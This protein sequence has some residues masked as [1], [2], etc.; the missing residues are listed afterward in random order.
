MEL[1]DKRIGVF[2]R[3]YRIDET[4]HEAIQSVLNQTYTNFKFYIMVNDITKRLLL[5]WEEKD[6]RIILIDGGPNDGFRTCAKKIASEN[7]Y[8]T[9]IDADDWYDEKYL[10]HLVEQIEKEEVDMVACGCFFFVD[11][12][13]I[14]WERSQVLMVWSK[15]DTA[16]VLPYIYGHFRTI[17]GKLIKSELLIEADFDILPDTTQYG[18]YGGDTLFMFN[19]L[20]YAER[21]AITDKSLYYYRMSQGSGTYS[22]NP[23]RLDSDEIVFHFV[24]NVLRRIGCFGEVQRRFLFWCYGNAL[25]DTSRLLLKS[26]LSI[27]EIYERLLYIFQKPLTKE[28]FNRECAGLLKI[29]KG[30]EPEK[31]APKVYDLVFTNLELCES[32]QIQRDCFQ[33]FQIIWPYYKDVISVAEFCILLKDKKMLDA[34]VGKE[35]TAMSEACLICLKSLDE[36]EKERALNLLEKFSPNIVLKNALYSVSFAEKYL[37]L[38]IMIV[39]NEYEELFNNLH[40]LFSVDEEQEE[41]LVELWINSAAFVENE[42]EF[43]LAKQFKV[44]ILGKK[45]KL[46]EAEEEYNELLQLG[47]MNE[48]MMLL[49]K[50]FGFKN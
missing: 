24:E 4:M 37:E 1:K 26:S 5:E 13:R 22:L 40:A 2:T 39:N 47:I 6:N 16:V 43:I 50:Y 9:T 46:F 33:I 34:F 12:N 3:I 27:E 48:N 8:A 36:G 25:I 14:V 29:D 17:W 38:L 15:S 44:E 20:S 7:T 42:I 18:G 11:Q 30:A 28:L 23:G 19:L 32:L 21:V 10:E 35:Y 49:K 45:G 41:E 31:V